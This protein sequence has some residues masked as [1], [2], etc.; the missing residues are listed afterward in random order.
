MILII[1]FIYILL[2]LEII[3]NKKNAI[4]VETSIAPTVYFS[5]NVELVS[6]KAGYDSDY[7][8]LTDEDGRLIITNYG[9]Q[10]YE[11]YVGLTPRA[12]LRKGTKYTFFLSISFPIWINEEESPLKHEI[13]IIRGLLLISMLDLVG[14]T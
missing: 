7:I 9:V 12:N 8:T 11:N 3:P 13:P 10:I 4:G 1:T 14:D 5:D 6:A 2:S